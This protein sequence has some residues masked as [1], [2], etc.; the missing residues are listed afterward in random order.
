MMLYQ[1]MIL[2]ESDQTQQAFDFICNYQSQMVDTLAIKET[3]G[4][5]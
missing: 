2:E 1:V 5:Y 3:K 4:I